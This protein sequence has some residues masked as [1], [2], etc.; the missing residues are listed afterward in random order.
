[1]NSKASRT[2]GRTTKQFTTAVRLAALV[3]FVEL[4][5][6]ISTVERVC[7]LLNVS[8]DV[9]TR[10]SSDLYDLSDPHVVRSQR[11]VERVSRRIGMGDRCLRRC[12]VLAIEIRGHAPVLRI[13]VRRSNDKRF[14]AHSWLEIGGG[15][16]DPEAERY[17]PAVN[18]HRAS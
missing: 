14:A 7:R 2:A 18:P 16:L 1:M 13:G 17:R 8:F 3:V 11:R 15:S 5:L 4:A 9:S 12:M 6:R 10:A